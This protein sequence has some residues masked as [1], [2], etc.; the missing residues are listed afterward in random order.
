MLYTREQEKEIW[1][2]FDRSFGV[3]I[4][5]AQRNRFAAAMQFIPQFVCVPCHAGKA[6]Q[7]A[8]ES[9]SERLKFKNFL[10]EHAPKLP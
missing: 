3:S 10:W 8:S 1:A 5:R 7:N 6:S 2:E 4:Q 9:I